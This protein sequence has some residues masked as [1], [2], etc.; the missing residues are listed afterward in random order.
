MTHW[1]KK[2]LGQIWEIWGKDKRDETEKNETQKRKA[3]VWKKERDH[4]DSDMIKMKKKKWNTE[5]K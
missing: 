2:N 3:A 1:C 5:E 4:N